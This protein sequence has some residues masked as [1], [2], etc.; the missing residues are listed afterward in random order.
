[1]F[2]ADNLGTMPHFAAAKEGW[3]RDVMADLKRDLEPGKVDP[4]QLRRLIGFT[5]ITGEKVIEAL[6]SY[7]VDGVKQADICRVYGFRKAF[8]SRKIGDINS[9]SVAVREIAP[10][11]REH[12]KS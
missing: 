12:P 4:E 9:V 3:M 7:F 2:L 10:F 6:H 11:Y 5:G 1:M 8:I